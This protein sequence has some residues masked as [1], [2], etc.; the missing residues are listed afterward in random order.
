MLPLW[1]VG[2]FTAALILWPPIFLEV[3]DLKDPP[4]QKKK[5]K[6]RNCSLSTKHYVDG[7]QMLEAS[8]HSASFPQEK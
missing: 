3:I 6:K 4:H 5:K 8:C 2:V 7:G 1:L